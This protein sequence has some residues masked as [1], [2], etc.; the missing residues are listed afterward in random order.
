MRYTAT[1][2]YIANSAELPSF[3]RA[4]EMLSLKELR[5][6]NDEKTTAAC[7]MVASGSTCTSPGCRSISSGVVTGAPP[8][9]P[10]GGK[11]QG[12]WSS[13]GNGAGWQNRGN[14]PMGPWFCYNP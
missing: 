14:R 9:G 13:P 7:A 10:R 5:L 12:G 11:K 3:S 4:R 2:D 6:T 1:T 8:K